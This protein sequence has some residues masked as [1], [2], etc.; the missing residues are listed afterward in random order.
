MEKKI[1]KVL[2]NLDKKIENIDNKF[3]GR[4][5]ILENQTKENTQMLQTLIQQK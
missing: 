5:D 2:E 3:E 4:F 1:L